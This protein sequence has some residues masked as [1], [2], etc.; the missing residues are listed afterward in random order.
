ME[1]PQGA[2]NLRHFE[3]TIQ[4]CLTGRGW[5]RW[6]NNDVL[7][8]L[9]EHGINIDHVRSIW[10]GRKHRYVFITFDTEDEAFDAR[11]LEPFQIGEVTLEIRGRYA[12]TDL[13][14]HWIPAWM[15]RDLIKSWIAEYGEIMKAEMESILS[16]LNISDD[17]QHGIEVATIENK[18]R[19]VKVMKKGTEHDSDLSVLTCR[20]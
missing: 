4:I 19:G 7:Q 17:S 5:W 10:K 20:L 9:A 11:N 8:A 3:R 14:I 1:I 6:T 15:D 16:Y 18:G 2:F 13:K 12:S